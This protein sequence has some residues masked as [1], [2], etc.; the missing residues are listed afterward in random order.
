MIQ[1]ACHCGAVQWQF[2]GMP[3]GAT[4]CNCTLCRRYGVLWAYDFEGE[5][6]VVS[7]PTQTY[8]PGDSISF[9]FCAHCGCVTYWRALQSHEDGRRRIAVN[10]RMS[11]P[12]A[13]APIPIFHFDGLERFEDLPQDGRCVADYWF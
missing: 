9:H 13:V 4:A 7:G 2:K 10:L 11:E 12:H 1:G 3:E 8:V 5:R 6:I